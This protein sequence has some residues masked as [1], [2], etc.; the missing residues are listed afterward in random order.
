MAKGKSRGDSHKSYQKTYNYAKQKLK[1]LERAVRKQPNNKQAL[2]AL[3]KFK[4]NPT[5]QM[6]RPMNKGGWAKYEAW[7]LKFMGRDQIKI[8]CSEGFA[9]EGFSEQE[10]FLKMSPRSKR[11]FVELVRP[12]RFTYLQMGKRGSK[13]DRMKDQLKEEVSRR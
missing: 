1:R 2:E 3:E 5:E 7:P 13:R 6:K 9:S 12:G 10:M 4:K 8:A 11:K